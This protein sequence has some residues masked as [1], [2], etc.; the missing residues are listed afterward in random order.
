MEAIYIILLIV[1]TAIL[2]VIS[3]ISSANFWQAVFDVFNDITNQLTEE[4]KILVWATA[5][6]ILAFA[7]VW[8]ILHS[9]G[10]C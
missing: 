9:C 7:G 10:G 4:A 3:F 6:W 2:T 1:G 5:G 8:G